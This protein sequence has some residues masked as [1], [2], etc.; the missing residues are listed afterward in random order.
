[1]PH[2]Y[3]DFSAIASRIPDS[4]AVEYCHRHGIDEITFG[5]LAALAGR[6]AATLAGL[7]VGAGERCAILADNHYRW[8]AAYLGI[9]RLGAVAVPLDTAYSAPQVR[10]VLND[11]AAKAL[12]V[13]TRYLDV[14]REATEASAPGP[15]I[16]LLSGSADGIGELLPAADGAGPPALAACP[17]TEADPAVVLYTSGTTSDPKGVVLTHGNLRAERAG[18]LG[19]ITVDERDAILAILPLFHAL[20][21]IANLLLPLTAGTR[22]VFLETVNSAE[23]MRAFT[24]RRITAFCVVPQFYYLLHQRITERVAA[25]GWAA[26]AAFRAMI[27]LNLWLRSYAGINAGRL[28]FRQAHQAVGGRMRIMVCGGSRF[29]PKVGRDLFGMGFNIVQAYG[30]TECSGAATATRLGDPHVDTVGPPLDGVEVRITPDPAGAPDREY[31]DGEVLIRGPIVMAGYHN[32]PDVN[33]VALAGGWLHT[34][35]LGYLD[36][37]GRLV[38]T[39]RKKEIIVLASGKNI[40]PEEIEAH[41]ARSP[42]IRELCVLGVSLPG[43]PS[44]ERLHA[45]IVPDLDL[46]RERRIVNFREIIRFDLESLS[47]GLPH[48]KRVLSFDVWMGDLPRTTTRKLKRHEIERRYRELQAGAERAD[49]QA[50]WSDADD[51]WAAEPV[52]ARIL[53]AIRETAP[54]GVTL[55]PDSNLELDLGLDS[56]ERVELISRL[57]H[58]FGVDVPDDVA[59]GVLTVRHLA[60]AIASLASGAFPRAQAAADPWARVLT[61]DEC[62]PVLAEVVRPKPAFGRFA[63]LVVRALHLGARLLLGLRVA[64]REHLPAAGTFILSPNHQSFLDAFLLAGALPYRTFRRLFFVGASEYFETPFMRRLAERMNVVPVDPDANLLRAM[65]AGAF[66]LR[67]NLI[68]TLFPEGERS[69]DGAPKRF[70]KGAAITALQAQVPIVPVALHGLFEIW[71]RGE[72]LRW[73][74]LLPWARTRCAIRFGRP[75]P[76]ESSPEAG[77]GR[78]ERHTALV[79]SAVV[80]MWE[81]L[82][83]ERRGT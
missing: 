1:M 39:G 14:A 48:H 69:P 53:A 45:V 4:I 35:D 18:A 11:S 2:V 25:S 57:E 21:Q 28:L 38:I 22:I 20:A 27:T 55:R 33:A 6:A 19:V 3:D 44:A 74:A 23:M 59:H 56:M 77:A 72:G 15:T 62:D 24:E 46:M 76:P 26:G 70:K 66:G 40:Y 13:S 41:Y 12:V 83:R 32:R 9:L 17:A 36:R 54:Q 78:Y 65:Q 16:L 31:E 34:G 47:L 63:F 71:P 79:R 52:A 49:E 50:E 37:G 60:E 42:F 82:E 30:L 81:E 29:D 61:A 8:L 7:G 10:T 73:S 5:E 64:G 51:A 58:D 43:A 75:V 67:R 80:K 68:L